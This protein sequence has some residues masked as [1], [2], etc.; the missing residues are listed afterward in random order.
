M[1]RSSASSSE[2]PSSGSTAAATRVYLDYAA[3]SPVD[4]RVV[5]VMRPVLEV[6]VTNPAAPPSLGLEA[7][8]SLDG[9]RAKLARLVGATPTGVVFTSGATEANNLAVKGL[10]SRGPGGHVV[11]SAVEHISVIN[12]CRGIE[13]YGVG[14]MYGGVVGIMDGVLEG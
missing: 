4:P 6:G 2:R 12:G 13:K 8:A 1:A 10:V 5:A 7:R 3:F 14:G 9:A 11:T